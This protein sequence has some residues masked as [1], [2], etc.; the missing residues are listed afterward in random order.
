MSLCPLKRPV[1]HEAMGCGQ[2]KLLASVVVP[3]APVWVPSQRPL[4]PSVA[5]L[6]LCIDLLAFTLQLR[7]TLEN[8]NWE[9][10]Q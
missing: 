2:K 7:K 3:P 10:N 5:S 6:E 8:L 9:I 1:V 4:A